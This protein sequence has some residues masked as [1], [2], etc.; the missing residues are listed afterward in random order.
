MWN[1]IGFGTEIE[2][3][4]GINYESPPLFLKFEESKLG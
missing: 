2:G 3:T 4:R 1:Q